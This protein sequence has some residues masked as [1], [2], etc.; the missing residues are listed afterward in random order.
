MLARGLKPPGPLLL[1]KKKLMTIES[2]HIRVI[3]SFSEAVDE[4]VRF[5][6]E[7]GAEVEIDMAG[8]DYHVLADLRNFKDAD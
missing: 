7:R 3:V 8:D 6:E 4:L 1:V 2:D 5:F